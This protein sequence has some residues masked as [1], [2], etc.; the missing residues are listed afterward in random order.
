MDQEDAGKTSQVQRDTYCRTTTHMESRIMNHMVV[1]SG[2]VVIR[3][4]GGRWKG[5]GAIMCGLVGLRHTFRCSV[6]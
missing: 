5:N 3:G 2:M 4:W 1:E 6:V